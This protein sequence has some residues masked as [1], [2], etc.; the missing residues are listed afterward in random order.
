MRG[1]RKAF[2]ATLAVDG[3]DL[4]VAP[5]EVCA[6]V[7]QNG[8]GKSTLMAILAGALRADAGTMWLDAAP[9]RP[10]DPLD[11]RN[12]GVAM[13][14]QEL[15]IAPHLSV[16]ENILLGMEPSRIG[17][18][19][20]DEMRRLASSALERLGHPEIAVDDPAGTLSPAG[21]QLVEI[22][23]ALAV[24]CRVLVLDEPTSSLTRS[25]TEHLFTVIKE[26]KRSGHAIVYISHFI[27][28]VKAI[29]DRIV[30]L[31]DGKLAGG[32]PAASLGAAEIVRLMVGRPVET[33][34]PRSPRARGEA[35]LELSEFG[36]ARATFTLHRGEIIGIAGLLGAGRTRLLRSLFGLEPVRAGRVRLAAYSGAAPPHVRWQQGM[37]FLSEDRKQEGLAS[38]LSI[39]DNMTLTRL[40][41]LGP[42]PFV[43]PSRQQRAAAGWMERLSIRARSPRQAVNELSGGNQQKVA[44]ARLLHHDV[45][46]LVLDEPTRGIDV[47]SKAQIYELIDALVSESSVPRPKA[48]LMV[49][50]YLPE[51]LGLCDRIAV[52]CRGALG[53]P[54]AV[55]DR[56]TEHELMLQA[57]GAGDAA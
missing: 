14:H 11:A 38:A 35:I 3:V 4:S 19:R 2:G 56:L 48:V 51:L 44:M 13:I 52:M 43:V 36:A 33:L 24:G 46:V 39:A 37:G 21:Q 16:A 45:D 32:G 42:G 18:I 6:I 34:Y 12:A 54:R 22:A 10:A 29:A 7:G 1:I 49:S 53:E 55:D 50:S 20:R 41:G 5:G 8:A 9:Y 17:V 28:E 26:L 31:R 25:D 40:D 23:R 30:V 15:S 27:E 47:A 57:T